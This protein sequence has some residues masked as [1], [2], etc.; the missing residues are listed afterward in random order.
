LANEHRN[1]RGRGG[2]RAALTLALVGFAVALG[3]CGGN[4]SS[5]TISTDVTRTGPTVPTTP[6][7]KPSP[8]PAYRKPFLKRGGRVCRYLYFKL[9]PLANDFYARPSEVTRADVAYFARKAAS[10]MRIAVARLRALGPPAR[11]AKELRKIYTAAAKGERNLMKAVKS[12]AQANRILLGYNPLA[13]VEELAVKYGLR[14]CDV[15]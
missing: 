15:T 5:S 1:P 14:D 2:S 8:I 6:T 3:A 7:R 9:K 4:D 11:D 12:R 13:R 10:Y